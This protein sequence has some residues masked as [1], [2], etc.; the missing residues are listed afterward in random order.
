MLRAPLWVPSRP[1]GFTRLLHLASFAIS[2]F[3]PLL[4]QYFWRPDVVITIAPSFFCA[5]GALILSRMCGSST[6]SWLH[7]QDFELDAA[8]ELGL[9]KGRFLRSLAESFEALILRGFNP[10]Q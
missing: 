6:I 8:F 9:L 10:C 7:I 1:S 3:V 4:A 5:P 2:S